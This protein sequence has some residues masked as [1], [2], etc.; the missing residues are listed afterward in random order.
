MCVA[1]ARPV[2]EIYITMRGALTLL[3]NISTVFHP[4]DV[5]WQTLCLTQKKPQNEPSRFLHRQFDGLFSAQSFLLA[6]VA[7]LDAHHQP[8]ASQSGGQK[9]LQRCRS[10]INR[11]MLSSKDCRYL[12]VCST[13]CFRRSLTSVIHHIWHWMIS[14]LIPQH[15]T[16]LA[17]TCSLHW[18]HASFDFIGAENISDCTF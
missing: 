11:G 5:I 15:S 4:F 13:S 17:I 3:S 14:D 1:F 10:L 9:S 16:C 8:L 2:H 6:R 7:T 12:Q 18:Q